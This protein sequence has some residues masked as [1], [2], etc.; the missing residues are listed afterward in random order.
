MEIKLYY[1]CYCTFMQTKNIRRS[2]INNSYWRADPFITITRCIFC[3][4]SLFWSWSNLKIGS[5]LSTCPFWSLYIFILQILISSSSIVFCCIAA[6]HFWLNK[7]K[8]VENILGYIQ[9]IF[10][11]FWRGCKPWENLWN[12]P[13]K[14]T[15]M[16]KTDSFLG[17]KKLSL[18]QNVLRDHATMQ[19]DVLLHFR[20]DFQIQK[21]IVSAIRYATNLCK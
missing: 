18:N 11:K 5:N 14:Y 13:R 3:V 2:G 16:F 21:R 19:Q 17:R 9:E 1:F 7:M 8:S 15:K 6:W 4:F 10:Y 20:V 12:C